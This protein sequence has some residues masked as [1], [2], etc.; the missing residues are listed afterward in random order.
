[1]I[2]KDSGFQV[3]L[4]NEIGHPVLGF[5]CIIH[6]D[7]LCAKDGVFLLNPVMNVVSKIINYIVANDLSKRQFKKLMTDLNAPYE[8]LLMYN[9]VRGLSRELSLERFVLCLDEIRL[10]LH[11]KKKF[12]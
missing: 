8:T 11:D 1:M 12:L 9:H 4:Q 6:L 10:F 3:L 5:H 7:A 2:G